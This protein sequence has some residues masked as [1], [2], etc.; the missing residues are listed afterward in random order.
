MRGTG[1]EAGTAF[2]TGMG[3]STTPMMFVDNV[4]T[5]TTT[6]GYAWSTGISTLTT[7]AVYTAIKLYPS[8]GTISGQISLYGLAK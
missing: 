8:S 5:A 3:W 7:A 2:L 6:T 1:S 4:N